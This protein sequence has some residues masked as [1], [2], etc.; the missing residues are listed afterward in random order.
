MQEV[1]RT[2]SSCMQFCDSLKVPEVSVLTFFQGLE[3]GGNKITF[4]HL[5][6]L[7]HLIKKNIWPLDR[8]RKVS[9]TF[10]RCRQKLCLLHNKPHSCRVLFK[11]QINPQRGIRYRCYTL[12]CL[13]ELVFPRVNLLR[14]QGWSDAAQA[15]PW[16][17]QKEGRG[18]E[19]LPGVCPAWTGSGDRVGGSEAPTSQP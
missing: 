1:E 11:W 5:N 18:S 12:E 6:R 14:N 4:R 3:K 2:S 17:C 8:Y 7:R 19:L 13:K 10:K 15:R 16:G 9:L